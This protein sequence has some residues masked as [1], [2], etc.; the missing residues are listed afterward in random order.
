[1]TRRPVALVAAVVLMA[2]AL[3]IVWLHWFLG[4]VV[5]GQRMSLAGLDPDHMSAGTLALGIGFGLY[6][7]ACGAVLLY[8]GLRDRAPNRFFRVLLIACAVV[9][10]LLGALTV[11]LV[12]WGAFG[13]MMLVFG[14]VVLSLIAYGEPG[15]GRAAKAGAA[16]RGGV[17]GTGP[18]GTVPG[19]QPPVV[20]GTPGAV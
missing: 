8:S 4:K 13:F 1:M 3:G 9:H 12:G 19:P 7:F 20:P 15:R 2:E 14:L 16:G 18:G 6:L 5:D 17:G 10:A 11:G